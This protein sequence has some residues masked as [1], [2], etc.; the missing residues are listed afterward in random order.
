M[1]TALSRALRMCLYRSLPT[2]A[3]LSGVGVALDAEETKIVQKNYRRSQS[4]ALATL[5]AFVTA[6]MAMVAAWLTL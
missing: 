3:Q 1:E 6:L 2:S 4:Y 5:V